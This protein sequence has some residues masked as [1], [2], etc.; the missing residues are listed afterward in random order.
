MI[1]FIGFIDRLCSL[2]YALETVSLDT[3]FDCDCLIVDFVD[4][5]Y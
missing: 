3:A 2:V 1:D 4:V 5:H